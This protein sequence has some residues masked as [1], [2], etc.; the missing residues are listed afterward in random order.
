MQRIAIQDV[1][2]LS[3]EES[4]ALVSSDAPTGTEV[5]IE[6][7]AHEGLPMYSVSFDGALRDADT[8]RGHYRS[9]GYVIL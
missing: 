1:R 5:I 9:K 4:F 6:V 3:F 7:L 8:V 2:D